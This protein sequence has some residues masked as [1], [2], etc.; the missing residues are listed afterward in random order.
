MCFFE[1]CLITFV[2]GNTKGNLVSLK[3]IS[4]IR[5]MGEVA[6]VAGLFYQYLVYH[7]LF[8]VI[9]LVALVTEFT[10]FCP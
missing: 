8:I 10:A 2:A 4:F 9:L 6:G 7:F 3:K 5:A 1:G